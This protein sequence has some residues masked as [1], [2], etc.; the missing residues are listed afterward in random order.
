MLDILQ[1]FVILCMDSIYTQEDKWLF[2][3]SWF[4]RQ[5]SYG[6]RSTPEV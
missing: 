4:G 5:T 3:H 6:K 1:A 2:K